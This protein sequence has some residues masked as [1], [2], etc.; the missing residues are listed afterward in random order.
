MVPKPNICLSLILLV[1]VWT[2]ISGSKQNFI[3]GCLYKHPHLS[4]DEFVSNYLYP[5]LDKVNKEGKRLILLRDFN[6]NPLDYD[7]S[8]DIPAFCLHYS[9]TFCILNYI[10]TNTNNTSFRN[11]N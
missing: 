4:T 7:L 3:V 9:F 6:I 5:T 1:S 10:I 11:F 2:Q 8:K